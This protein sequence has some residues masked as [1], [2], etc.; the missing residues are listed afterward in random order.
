MLWYLK[1]IFIEESTLGMLKGE[2]DG[3]MAATFSEGGN[4]FNHLVWYKQV[5]GFLMV[6]VIRAI[7][8]I[9]SAALVA[10]IIAI[11]DTFRVSHGL[12][13]PE[14]AEALA[15]I[16]GHFGFEI[17]WWM[18]FLTSF[19]AWML[20]QWIVYVFLRT[21]VNIVSFIYFALKK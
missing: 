6:S 16:Q 12:A 4:H 1:H 9:P 8:Y 10:L 11:I 5:F 3:E 14:N 21:I 17:K 18:I 19:I 7:A 20:L 2:G 15:E 13:R